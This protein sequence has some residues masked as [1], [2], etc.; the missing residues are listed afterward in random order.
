MAEW[1][2]II[3]VAFAQPLNSS[4]QMGDLLVELIYRGTRMQ[5]MFM[6][7]LDQLSELSEEYRNLERLLHLEETVRE[8]IDDL[9]RQ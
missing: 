9:R 5:L 2:A 6:H 7:V 1:D 3:S 4:D 8:L